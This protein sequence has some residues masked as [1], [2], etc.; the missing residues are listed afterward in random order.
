MDWEDRATCVLF[1]DGAGA[2]VLASSDGERGILSGYMK[3][4]GRLADLLGI[5]GGGSAIPTNHTSVD[6]KR[7]Y[8]HM[9]GREVFKHAVR[10]MVDAAKHGLKM[11]GYKDDDLDLL[12]SHQANIR[13]I[14]AIGERLKLP[15]EKIF[16]NLQEYG[17]T[18]AAS[19]PLAMDQAKK[20]GKLKK[21][22]LCL[23]V[24]FGGGFTWASS[25]IKF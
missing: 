22:D 25:L 16:I 8:I 21:G 2:V 15:K 14:G 19:I 3:S 20:E 5:A 18:S 1:G 17:N 9:K 24:A 12:I 4:D 11:A 23:L 7:H 6:E 13:I 10:T